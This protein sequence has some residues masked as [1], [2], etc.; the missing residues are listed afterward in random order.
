MYKKILLSIKPK[1]AEQILNGTKKFEY[2]KIKPKFDVNY[3]FVYWTF[4]KMKVI[5]MVK[6]ESIIAL[7]P[8]KMWI[9]TYHSSGISKNDFFKYYKNSKIA[10]AFKLGK[11]IYFK[12][13]KSLSYYNVKHAP[14]SFVYI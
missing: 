8:Q 6:V 13:P 2:R 3:I 5:M 7:P 4:P 1:Y 11:V 9:E 10:Y 12:K 14:Q